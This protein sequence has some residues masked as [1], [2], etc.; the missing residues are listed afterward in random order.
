MGSIILSF[1]WKAKQ[2]QKIANQL[3]VTADTQKKYIDEGIN[4]LVDL[5]IEVINMSKDQKNH[6]EYSS[7]NSSKEYIKNHGERRRA[8]LIDFNFTKILEEL[9]EENRALYI[10]K[11]G[12]GNFDKLMIKSDFISSRALA[13]LPMET[14]K[15]YIDHIGYRTLKE[16]SKKDKKLEKWLTNW[17]DNVK[18]K[19]IAQVLR[20]FHDM[21]EIDQENA[22][23]KTY[24]PCKAIVNNIEYKV[25]FFLINYYQV[26]SAEKAINQLLIEKDP[27]HVLEQATDD[28]KVNVVDKIDAIKHGNTKASYEYELKAYHSMKQAL[29]ENVNEAQK[30]FFKQKDL[31]DDRDF[32]LI[33]RRGSKEAQYIGMVQK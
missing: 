22:P 28:F 14:Q 24:A 15:Q 3:T 29:K 30:Y 27:L 33:F 1:S 20:N 9:S 6:L 31:G 4:Q 23:K 19:S 26:N 2:F 18:N 17:T 13:L 12:I 16:F 7:N 8:A 11:L 32:E 25:P 10:D 5:T 21:C